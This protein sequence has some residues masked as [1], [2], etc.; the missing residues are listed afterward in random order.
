MPEYAAFGMPFLFASPAQAFKLLDGAPKFSPVAIDPLED[1]AV[2]TGGKAEEGPLAQAFA[3]DGDIVAGKTAADLKN[4]TA[5]L[6]DMNAKGSVAAKM[7]ETTTV[8][9]NLAMGRLDLDKLRAQ[10]ARSRQAEEDLAW[11]F[12]SARQRPS[13]IDAYFG[14]VYYIGPIFTAAEDVLVFFGEK[15]QANTV[16]TLVF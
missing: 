15:L 4:F 12:K 8:D 5:S 6:G 11:V 13:P 9:A 7:G 3:L 1:I 14:G 10:L 16:V 2:L